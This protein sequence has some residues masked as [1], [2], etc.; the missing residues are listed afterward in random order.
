MNNKLIILS[1]FSL[2]LLSACSQTRQGEVLTFEEQDADSNGYI[3]SSEA[4]G[5]IGRHFKKIDG[6]GD[7]KVNIE[8]FQKYMGKGRMTPPE[9]METPEPGAAPY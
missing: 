6:N 4:T 5:N 7:G 8:E 1:V 2:L 9:E 3:S